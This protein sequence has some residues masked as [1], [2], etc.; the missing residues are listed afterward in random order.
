[1]VTHL[2]VLYL[3]EKIINENYRTSEGVRSFN[4]DSTDFLKE[5]EYTD[6]KMSCLFSLTTNIDR[7]C[8]TRD[9]LP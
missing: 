7:L 2:L 9:S 8:C 5:E 1:M 4:T 6:A 3:R